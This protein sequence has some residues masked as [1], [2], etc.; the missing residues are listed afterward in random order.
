MQGAFLILKSCTSARGEV[1]ILK[2]EITRDYRD[3]RL[4]RWLSKGEKLNVDEERANELIKA[5]VAKSI[6]EEKKTVKVSK[7]ADNTNNAE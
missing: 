3:L 1:R 2:V 5:M 6:D 7:A 4:N